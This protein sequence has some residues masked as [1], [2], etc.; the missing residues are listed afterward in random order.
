MGSTISLD[1]SPNYENINDCFFEYSDHDQKYHLRNSDPRNL[2]NPGK[3]SFFLRITQPITFKIIEMKQY[4]EIK[5]L[6][7][8]NISF[9]NLQN[10]HE[11]R[12]NS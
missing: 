5:V 2:L 12:N 8:D 7:I 9:K 6:L 4:P 11:E 1:I 10:Y 3:E